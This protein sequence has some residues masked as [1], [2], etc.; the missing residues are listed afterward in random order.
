MISFGSDHTTSSLQGSEITCESDHWIPVF[1]YPASW[2]APL[3]PC[4][5]C[6]CLAAIDAA[7]SGS[8]VKAKASLSSD[9]WARQDISTE[10][11]PKPLE[12]QTLMPGVFPF[13][14]LNFG[15]TPRSQGIFSSYSSC[16]PTEADQ[17]PASPSQTSSPPTH[18]AH[19]QTNSVQLKHKH[20]D[21]EGQPGENPS[22]LTCLLNDKKKM[23]RI[24]WTQQFQVWFH[25]QWERILWQAK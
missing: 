22:S 10:T 1:T 12:E 17:I 24:S 9:K 14:L 15:H 21:H 20:K 18:Q 4:V 6:E 5:A 8:G 19:E 11:Q 2:H 23:L 7:F 3:P 25:P 13:G 16:L